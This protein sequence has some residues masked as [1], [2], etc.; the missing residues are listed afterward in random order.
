VIPMRSQE[1]IEV[2]VREARIKA[3]VVRSAGQIMATLEAMAKTSHPD[4]YA[5]DVICYMENVRGYL[6]M[7][8]SLV[9]LHQGYAVEE[10][11]S[12]LKQSP[13]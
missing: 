11:R 6:D 3:A 7:K 12:L 2:E 8:L 13:N 10:L 9:C 4:S 5:E 1:D